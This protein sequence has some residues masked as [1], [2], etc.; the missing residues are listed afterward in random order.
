MGVFFYTN[1]KS[2]RPMYKIQKS[3]RGVNGGAATP[4]G[5]QLTHIFKGTNKSSFVDSLT[6][7]LCRVKAG[8]MA[9]S[10]SHWA[11]GEVHT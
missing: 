3:F 6:A 10:S 5:R 8:L 1:L 4:S 11:I 9:S 7:F 2:V